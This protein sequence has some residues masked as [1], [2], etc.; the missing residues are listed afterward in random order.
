MEHLK[1]KCLELKENPEEYYGRYIIYPFRA[2]SAL[3]FGNAL[4]RTL[5]S[6]LEGSAI[7]GVYIDGI[8]HEFSIIPGLREDTLELLL[9]IKEIVVINESKLPRYATLYVEGPKI[10][11]AADIEFPPEVK[12]V[13]PS[14]YL[15]TLSKNAALEIEFKIDNG[16]GYK[17]SKPIDLED[18]LDFMEVDAIFMP[19]KRVNYS[20]E[21]LYKNDEEFIERLVFEIWTNGTMTPN[22]ALS[23]GCTILSTTFFQAKQEFDNIKG[24]SIESSNSSKIE[25]FESRLIKNF[26]DTD[27]NDL[28]LSSRAY[29]GLKQVGINNL[30][31]LLDIL[32]N[33]PKQLKQVRNFGKK[34]FQEVINV[35]EEQYK[36]FIDIEINKDLKSD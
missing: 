30:Q 34:S 3:T 25:D 9:N 26:E 32:T 18:E 16:I 11:T 12:L 10:V 21:K 31:E 28:K 15:G 20:I 6:N 8:D 27:V 33:D 23:S 5:L 1:I 14:H 22:F 2:N 36:I 17:L 19:V 29:K 4:R 13:N 7:V 24:P 35:L